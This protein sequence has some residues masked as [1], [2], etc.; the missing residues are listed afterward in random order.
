MCI[1]TVLFEVVRYLVG[2]LRRS[3]RVVLV[4]TFVGLSWPFCYKHLVFPSFLLL[5]STSECIDILP[6]HYL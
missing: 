2:I 5:I 4:E 6:L 1:G 3:I